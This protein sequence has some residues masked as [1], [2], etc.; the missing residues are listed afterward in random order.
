MGGGGLD[1]LGYTDFAG[2]GVV[3]LCGAAAALAAVSILGA[4]RVNMERTD[5]Y[6]LFQDLIFPSQPSVL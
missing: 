1:A 3:H 4:R 5:L 6:M 2:S